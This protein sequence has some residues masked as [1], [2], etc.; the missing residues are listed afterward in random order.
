MTALYIILGILLCLFLY[1]RSFLFGN[2]A[3]KLRFFNMRNT[4]LFGTRRFP[5]FL[6]HNGN[7][8]AKHGRLCCRN[9]SDY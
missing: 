7:E 6:V 1:Q 2:T 9:T 4:Q 5:L 8:R 3:C